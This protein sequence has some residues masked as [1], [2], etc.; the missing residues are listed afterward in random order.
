M[1]LHIQWVSDVLSPG[2]KRGQGVT[3]T[4]HPI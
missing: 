2:V 4:I 3:L 1:S